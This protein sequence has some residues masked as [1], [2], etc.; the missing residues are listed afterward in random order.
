MELRALIFDVDG[1]LADTEEMHRRA[2]NAAFAEHGLTWNWGRRVYGD[3]LQTAGGKER[4]LEFVNRLNLPATER[5]KLVGLVPAI[6]RSKT[7][8]YG[9]L[10]ASRSELRPGIAGLLGE[11]RGAGLKLAVASTT[12]RS[13]ID[14]LVNAACGTDAREL[15]DVIMAGDDVQRKKPAP[16]IYHYALACLDMPAGACIAFEDSAIGLRAAKEGGLFTVVTPTQWTKRDDFKRADL[17]LDDLSVAG[18]L[19]FLKKAHSACPL[20]TVQAA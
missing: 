10:L 11:A 5:E 15:F 13:N 4:I 20:K 8:H 9:R 7:L 19:A 2:F 14:C 17:R 18:G 6:H 1:T 3:L 16:D 12:T